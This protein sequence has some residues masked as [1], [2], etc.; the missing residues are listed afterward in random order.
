MWRP[1]AADCSGERGGAHIDCR[2]GPGRSALCTDEGAERGW[3]R[4]PTEWVGSDDVTIAG[5]AADDADAISAQL[6]A[7]EAAPLLLLACSRR[8]RSRNTAET[9]RDGNFRARW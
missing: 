5:G 9:W 8:Q 1:R 2:R 6:S 4:G 3:A 7:F